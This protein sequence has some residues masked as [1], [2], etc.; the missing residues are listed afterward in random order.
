MS[1]LIPSPP[2]KST[3]SICDNPAFVKLLAHSTPSK[4]TSFNPTHSQVSNAFPSILANLI[5][6]ISANPHNLL[7]LE[8]H[9]EELGWNSQGMEFHESNCR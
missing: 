5:S 1:S 6:D 2:P 3:Q 9:R 7:L 8:L 4:T